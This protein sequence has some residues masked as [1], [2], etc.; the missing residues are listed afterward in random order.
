MMRRALTTLIALVIVTGLGAAGWTMMASDEGPSIPVAP[1][2]RGQVD[3]TVRAMGDIRAAR[4][5]QVF[6]PPVGG[7]LTSSPSPR[8][9]RR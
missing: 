2:Q 7:T 4:A 1:V 5:V 6:T 3:V 9:V 8:L